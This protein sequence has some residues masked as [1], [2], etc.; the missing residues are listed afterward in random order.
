MPRPRLRLSALSQFTISLD[1][2]DTVHW[3]S[4]RKCST[5]SRSRHPGMA[6]ASICWCGS[7]ANTVQ[8]RHCPSLRRQRVTSR[9]RLADHRPCGGT[10]SGIMCRIAISRSS[11]PLLHTC[12]CWPSTRRH[13]RRDHNVPSVLAR[14]S[15]PPCHNQSSSCPVRRRR[16]RS[17]RSRPQ[18]KTWFVPLCFLFHK[19]LLLSASVCQT[20]PRPA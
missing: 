20:W 12:A 5:D 1:E 6:H 16:S 18:P 13:G 14:P 7:L 19:P 2:H 17:S 4:R 9:R 10:G 3:S 8:F 11:T 15:R